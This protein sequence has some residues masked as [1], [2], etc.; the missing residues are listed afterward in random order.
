M[1]VTQPTGEIEM[2]VEVFF[3]GGQLDTGYFDG[4][5]F[6]SR[7][8][9]TARMY[10]HSSDDNTVYAVKIPK[11]KFVKMTNIDGD[12]LVQE[13]EDEGWEDERGFDKNDGEYLWARQHAAI[14]KAIEDYDAEIVGFEDGIVIVDVQKKFKIIKTNY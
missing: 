6:W 9:K 3:H 13:M 5:I 1:S 11:D 7:D 2:S 10:A 12:E 8:Y 14:K 4:Q